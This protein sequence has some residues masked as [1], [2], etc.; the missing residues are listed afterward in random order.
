MKKLP[1]PLMQ[2][3][4]CACGLLRALRL[5]GS[6]REVVLRPAPERMALA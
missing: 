2:R 6:E 5:R 1:L 4:P 3:V